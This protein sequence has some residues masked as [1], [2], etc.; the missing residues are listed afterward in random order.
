MFWRALNPTSQLRNL[1][2]ARKRRLGQGELRFTFV[3]GDVEVEDPA[4]DI[5]ARFFVS[6]KEYGFVVR[7]FEGRK[8]AWARDFDNGTMLVTNPEGDSHVLS[9][10]VPAR[11]FFIDAGGY[12]LQDTGLVPS[13]Q[14]RG[15][16]M[17]TVRMTITATYDLQGAE[18]EAARIA[19]FELLDAALVSALRGS[20]APVRLLD[21]T[22]ESSGLIVEDPQTSSNTDFS[23]LL[24]L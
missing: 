2:V 20:S 22:F 10:K 15:A 18:P 4:L 11:I 16:E 19:L 3:H 23:K 9:P 14:Y 8:T 24:D 1:P 13:A 21:H 6:P 7:E 17:A 5:S 12:A